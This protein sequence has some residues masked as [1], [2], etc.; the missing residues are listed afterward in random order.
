M[1]LRPHLALR[2][3]AGRP[4]QDHAVARAAEVGRHLLRPRE[5][6]VACHGPARGEVVVGV[7]GAQFLDPAELH[8]QRFLDRV[9]VGVLVVHAD[10]AAFGARSVVADDVEEERVVQFAALLER[11]DQPADFVVGVFG[12]S[13]KNLHLAFEQAL[14]VGRELVPVLDVRR[15]RRKHRVGRHHA[16]L[17]LPRQRFLAHLVPALRELA[18]VLRGI[19]LGRVMRSVR[20]AG[21]EVHVERLVGRERLLRV[22]PGQ[23]LIGHVGREVIARRFHV[24]IHARRAVID[25]RVPLVGLA[26]DEAVELVESRAGRP[27]VVRTG[28]G[29]FPGRRF[30]VLAERRRA[31][32]VHPQHLRRPA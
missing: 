21:G 18:F 24:R 23:R 32:A 7:F 6:R 8:V 31:V 17:L 3:D 1:E 10:H 29:A 12:E 5:R 15:L 28:H 4:V 13:G 19:G 20:R 27:A 16:Q 11:I 25:H 2:F 9:E 26:A 14:F 22:H 30:V